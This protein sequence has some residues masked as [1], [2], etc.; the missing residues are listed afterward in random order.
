MYVNKFNNLNKINII[1]NSQIPKLASE[2]KK[3]WVGAILVKEIKCIIKNLLTNK[4]QAK[5]FFNEFS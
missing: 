2:K 4:P 5:I 1:W 3:T